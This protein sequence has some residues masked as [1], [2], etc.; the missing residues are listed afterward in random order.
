MQVSQPRG[1]CRSISL[2]KPILKTTFTA[3]KKGGKNGGS[4]TKR[5]KKINNNI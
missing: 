3:F 1:S 2:E 5:R 4:L